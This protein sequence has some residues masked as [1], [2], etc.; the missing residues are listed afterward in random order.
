M[1]GCKAQNNNKTGLTSEKYNKN[2]MIEARGL[3]QWLR[4]L[5]SPPEDWDGVPRTHIMIKKHL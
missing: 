4:V 3:G 5:N 1:I 2:Y